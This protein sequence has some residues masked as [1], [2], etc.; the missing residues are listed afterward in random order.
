MKLWYASNRTLK[1]KK[2]D[3]EHKGKI[4]EYKMTLKE[5]QRKDLLRNILISF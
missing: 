1:E 3:W 2:K 4:S 5:L